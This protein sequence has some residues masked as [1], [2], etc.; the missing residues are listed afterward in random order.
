[1]NKMKRLWRNWQTRQTQ[2]LVFCDVQVRVLSGAQSQE[3]VAS[4]FL[5]FLYPPKISHD[6]TNKNI[7]LFFLACHQIKHY[8][9]LQDA[10]NVH[11][12][13]IGKEALCSSCSWKRR[14]FLIKHKTSVI[15]SHANRR[16]YLSL[17]S[18][19]RVSYD[20]Q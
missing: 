7:F 19:L 16:G 9:C 1:M 18:C 8:L 14:K 10:R 6:L 12:R 3:S 5:A 17:H 15:V 11:A 4:S 2:D 20:L 13:H